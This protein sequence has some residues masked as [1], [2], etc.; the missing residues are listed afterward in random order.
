MTGSLLVKPAPA[1]AD[2]FTRAILFL[3]NETGLHFC[4]PRKLGAMWLVEDKNSIIGKLGPEP[5]EAEFSPQILAQRLSKRTAPIKALLCDQTF[6]AGIGNMYAD[7][8]LFSA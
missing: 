1:E 2:R 8:A 4:D 3:D 7:E 6:V 5:L